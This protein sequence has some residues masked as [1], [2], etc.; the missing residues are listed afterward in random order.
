M[1]EVEGEPVYTRCGHAHSEAEIH[2]SRDMVSRAMSSAAYQRT[3]MNSGT[4]LLLYVTLRYVTIPNSNGSGV[5]S[6]QQV[7]DCHEQLNRIMNGDWDPTAV[8]PPT[9]AYPY[10]ATMPSPRIAF[11]PTSASQI[12]EGSVHYHVASNRPSGVSFTDAESVMEWYRAQSGNPPVVTG[13]IYVF[14]TALSNGNILG[15]ADSIGPLGGSG[16]PQCIV[17]HPMTVGKRLAG[18]V[19]TGTPSS[20]YGGGMTLVHELGHKLGL[21]HPFPGSAEMLPCA[22]SAV[23]QVHAGYPEYP[24][25]KTDNGSASATMAVAPGGVL[26]AGNYTVTGNA[27]DNVGRDALIVTDSRTD[28]DTGPGVPFRPGAFKFLGDVGSVTRYSCVSDVSGPRE[29]FMLIMDYP[30]DSSMAGF[31]PTNKTEMRA[32]VAANTARYDSASDGAG[33]TGTGGTDTTGGTGTTGSTGVDP[34]TTSGDDP[35]TNGSSSTGEDDGLSQATIIGI[36]FGSIA[37]FVLLAA[38]IYVLNKKTPDAKAART[39]RSA[40]QVEE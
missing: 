1:G 13:C 36:V 17:M 40:S 37:G 27:F 33:G 5:P 4:D 23:T 7:R 29:P 9:A 2:D 20:I 18:G 24:R 8:V 22:H 25:Q 15:M 3:L 39:A 32:V 6:L 28:V 11:R 14:I 19:N 10:T 12:A 31:G 38:L 26:T 21:L 16:T 30:P 34:V 35:A